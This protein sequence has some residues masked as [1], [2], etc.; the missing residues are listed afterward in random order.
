[1]G[2]NGGPVHDPLEIRGRLSGGPSPL[3]ADL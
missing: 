1:M 2:I 3:P